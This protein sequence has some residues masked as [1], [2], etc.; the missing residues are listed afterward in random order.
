MSL[1]RREGP[2][3]KASHARALVLESPRLRG[4][5]ASSMSEDTLVIK[6]TRHLDHSAHIQRH[7][8]TV[9]TFVLT[10]VPSLAQGSLIIFFSA[11][12]CLHLFLFSFFFFCTSATSLFL[13]KSPPSAYVSVWP[14]CHTAGWGIQEPSPPLLS[15]TACLSLLSALRHTGLFCQ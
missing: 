9:H 7:F 14:S 5:T 11:S 6:A 8:W 3:T 2:G 4:V 10:R 12:A 13:S 1:H 15:T